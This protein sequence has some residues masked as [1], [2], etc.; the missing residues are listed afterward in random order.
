MTRFAL[1]LVLGCASAPQPSEPVQVESSGSETSSE[2]DGQLS[3]SQPANIRFTLE[4]A[5]LPDVAR[6][7]GEVSGLRVVL[8]S[9]VDRIAEC[10]T[11]SVFEP[12]PITVDEAIAV[13]RQAYAARGVELERTSAQLLF[14][15]APNALPMNCARVSSGAQGQTAQAQPAGQTAQAAQGQTAQGQTAQGQTA[16]RQAAQPNG[17]RTAR[18]ALSSVIT[19][20][21]RRVS[22]SEVM[23]TNAALDE[24][25]AN[26]ATVFSSARLIP[27]EENGRIVAIKLYGVRRNSLLGRL[28]FRNGD[29]LQ[30]ING[31]DVTNVDAALEAYARLRSAPE[32]RVELQRRG[33][34]VTQTIRVVDSLP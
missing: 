8:D 23:I 7:L 4:R 19:D 5:A 17:S 10:L 12:N 20:G 15:L 26:Q 27:H 25:L 22:A 13:T 3:E 33:Q 34:A 18:S 29:G 28:G 21:I 14:S 24:V 6:P 11:I 2:A 31:Y 30:T 1:V 32:L 16:Q 9:E